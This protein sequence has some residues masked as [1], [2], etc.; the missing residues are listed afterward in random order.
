MSPGVIPVENITEMT[1][2]LFF[3]SEMTPGLISFFLPDVYSNGPHER[4]RITRAHQSRPQPVVERQDAGLE[5]IPEVHV[6]GAAWEPLDDLAERE[7]VGRRQAD[8][9]RAHQARE[10]GFRPDT[11]VV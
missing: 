6:R 5:L 3:S 1:P 9:T 4:Q 8:R 10:Q 11:P 2:G 7:I